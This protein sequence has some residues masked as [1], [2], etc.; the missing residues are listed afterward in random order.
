MAKKCLISCLTYFPIFVYVFS[1][2]VT[3]VGGGACR[4]GDYAQ[5]VKVLWIPAKV[6][7]HIHV[8]ST[9][10]PLLETKWLF[11]IKTWPFLWNLVEYIRISAVKCNEI[12]GD[13]TKAY[14]FFIFKICATY[15]KLISLTLIQNRFLL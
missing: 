12:G 7:E 14:H 2:S 10:S 3:E 15:F 5:F 9:V 13:Y 11:V 1:L 4:E 8:P 6:S